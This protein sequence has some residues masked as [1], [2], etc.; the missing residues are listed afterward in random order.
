MYSLETIHAMQDD[1]AEDAQDRGQ[2]PL[3]LD[4]AD[5]DA[6]RNGGAPRNPIPNMGSYIPP[7]WQLTDRTDGPGVHGDNAGLALVDSTGGGAPNELAL[8]VAQFA[9]WA[10]AG[11]AYGVYEVGQFQVVVAEYERIA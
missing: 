4:A 8:T 9:D 3:T 6:I 10:Q 7:G 2:E 5:L 11:R 1:A